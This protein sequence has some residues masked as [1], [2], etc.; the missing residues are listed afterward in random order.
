MERLRKQI[1]S[2]DF[3]VEGERL[4]VTTS[5]GVAS[6][7]VNEIDE[8]DLFK[9][10]DEALYKAKKEGRNRVIAAYGSTGL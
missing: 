4:N 2:N 3:L 6:N 5:I 9:L 10:A 8:S 7:Q 1:E